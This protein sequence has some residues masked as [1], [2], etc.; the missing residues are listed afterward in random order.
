[1]KKENR[2]LLLVW[3]SAILLILSVS[4]CS[5]LRKSKSSTYQKTDSVSV[6]KVDS[7][8]VFKK[9]SVFTN[10]E[11]KEDVNVVEI[12]FDSS[13]TGVDTLKI[14]INGDD[15][16]SIPVKRAVKKITIRHSQSANKRDSV[17][18]K[19][20]KAVQVVKSDSTQV[21]Q[22]VKVKEKQKAKCSFPYVWLVVIGGILYLLWRR[23]NSFKIL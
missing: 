20:E 21:K 7:S 23:Y 17:H 10:H 6:Q 3:L 12:E 18:T 19:E 15:Y 8:V 5:V 1:M 11:Q 22:E 9:D 4:S 14:P 13:E 2:F 16:F